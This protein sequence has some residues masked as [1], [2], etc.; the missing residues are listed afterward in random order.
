MSCIKFYLYINIHLKIKIMAKKRK[1][2]RNG[3][4]PY[5]YGS[6]SNRITPADSSFPS[7]H[8]DAEDRHR[9]GTRL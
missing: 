4:S 3:S 8:R 6:N 9:G 7:R 5:D 1:R 2:K